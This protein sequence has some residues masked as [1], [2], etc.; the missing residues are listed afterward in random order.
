MSK[1]AAKATD[2]PS[3]APFVDD[4]LLY[5]LARASHQVSQQF[6]KTVRAHGLKVPEW[7]VLACLSDG[8][9]TIGELAATTLFQQPTLTKIVDRMADTGL[10]SRQ[11]H[12]ADGR[13]VLVAITGEGRRRTEALIAEARSH[14]D[15]IL[16]R[17]E[18]NEARALKRALHDLIARTSEPD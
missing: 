4:Y 5:L 13:K 11:P 9:A 17:Y 15:T 18:P 8:P 1:A 14:E 6:H 10:V 7:R 2:K 12:A 16:E 3:Q